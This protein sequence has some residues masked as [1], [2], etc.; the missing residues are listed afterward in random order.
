MNAVDCPSIYYSQV[1]GGKQVLITTKMSKGFPLY[2]LAI[3][4]RK[5][6]RFSDQNK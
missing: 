2:G 4:T 3:I 6:N 5:W 1:M